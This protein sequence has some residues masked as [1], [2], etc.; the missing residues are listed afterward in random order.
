MQDFRWWRRRTA[1]REPP[2]GL[3]EAVRATVWAM[4]KHRPVGEAT[5]DLDATIIV[6]E[7]HEAAVEFIPSKPPVESLQTNGR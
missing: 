7:K 2:A 4:Q 1:R 5:T 3:Q 6:S